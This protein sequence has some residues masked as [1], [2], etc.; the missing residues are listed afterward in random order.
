MKIIQS[1]LPDVIII[2]PEI[3]GD[4]RGFFMETWHQKKFKD[5]GIDVNFVQDNHSRSV[6]NTLR[7]LHFQIQHSQGKLIRVIDGSIFDVVVD[8]RKSSPTFGNWYGHIL[9][10]EN[11]QLL[12]C[13]PGFAHGF[14]VTSEHADVCYKCTEY[15]APESERTLYWD[16][17]TVGIEWPLETGVEPILSDKDRNGKS[18][19]EVEHYS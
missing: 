14:F 9:S 16:D 19:C 8:L 12:W 3:F 15:Y 7:G 11:M 5:N 10:F 2:E 13:P 6:K 18:L 4:K 17:E 1:R